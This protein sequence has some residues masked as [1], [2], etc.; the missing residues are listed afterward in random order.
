MGP[1]QNAEHNAN[2]ATST[3]QNSTAELPEGCYFDP[4]HVGLPMP[5]ADQTCGHCN[6]TVNGDAREWKFE[7]DFW[8]C[9]KCKDSYW[10]TS[11]C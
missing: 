2:T 3:V 11:D 7:I 6:A 1:L 10:H 9:P 5:P 8:F 4:E